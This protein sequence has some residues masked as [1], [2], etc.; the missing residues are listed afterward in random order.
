MVLNSSDWVILLKL[1]KYREFFLNFVQVILTL[2][3]LNY[4]PCPTF[5]QALFQF[6]SSVQVQLK[7][8]ISLIISVRPHPTYPGNY[9][10][11]CKKVYPFAANLANNKYKDL[12]HLSHTIG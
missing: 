11:S 12:A 5:C 8:E 6:A 2:N 3:K 1:L 10:V 7:T 9:R 4:T